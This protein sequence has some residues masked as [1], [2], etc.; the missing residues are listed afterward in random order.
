V[1]GEG[2]TGPAGFDCGDNAIS[3][4]SSP[5]PT[6]SNSTAQAVSVLDSDNSGRGRADTS[7]RR[8]S[9]SSRSSRSRSGSQP[10][11]LS[12]RLND[13]PEAN[14]RS[15]RSDQS[16]RSSVRNVANS[17]SGRRS[18]SNSRR[19]SRNAND[20]ASGD[21]GDDC[22]DDDDNDSSSS[23][24][25]SSRNN[26][27]SN[28]GGGTGSSGGGN[29]DDNSN[30]GGGGSGSGGGSSGAEGETAS[31]IEKWEGTLRRQ[32][33]RRRDIDKIV[34]NYLV[35]N[36]YKDVAEAFIKDSGV[37]PSV[38]LESI[39]DR[40][41]IRK[42]VYEG[43][44]PQVI[45]KLNKINPEILQRHPKLYFLLQ[46]QR[47]IEL[48]RKSPD[49]IAES[50]DFARKELAPRA[51]ENEEFLEE[52]ER[53][54]TLLAFP[55]PSNTTVRHLL[56]SERMEKVVNALN[57]AILTLQCQSRDPKL[58]SLLRRLYTSRHQSC[59]AIVCL[60][61]CYS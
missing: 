7:G 8:S 36:G 31:S 6:A 5:A 26:Q 21:D 30:S 9:R 28:R 14:P 58:L 57:T 27:G 38:P 3:M 4:S 54:M 33:V 1:A 32:N 59:F 39:S 11:L 34:M 56:S 25:R 18:N 15:T 50:L 17:S 55:N 20:A 12:F 42:A 45:Q 40:M 46:Q 29:E 19:G 48:I 53:V 47:L 2:W 49:N 37:E 16:R 61:R 23:S 13:D 43:N 60:R 51:A 52:M 44:I 24:S 10:A 41:D 35:V 22:E